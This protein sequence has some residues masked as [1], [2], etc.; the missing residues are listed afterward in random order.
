MN[1][2]KF[3]VELE[4]TVDALEESDAVDVLEDGLSE[5]DYAGYKVTKMTIKGISEV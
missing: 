3:C 5:G 4:L 1:T 2:Y